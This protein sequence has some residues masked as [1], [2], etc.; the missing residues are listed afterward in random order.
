M[1]DEPTRFFN[2]TKFIT[3]ISAVAALTSAVAYLI[4]G[5]KTTAVTVNLQSEQKQAPMA[6]EA[7]DF[8]VNYAYRSSGQEAFKPLTDGSVLFS[9]DT[10]KIQF[11]PQL[12]S[13]VYIF[14]RDSS[15]ALFQLFPMREFNGVQVNNLNPVQA[16][17]SYILPAKDKAF[18]LDKQTGQ[19]TIFFMAA[20]QPNKVL[21]QQAQLMLQAQ[22][23][24][25]FEQAREI[26][27]QM[28][29]GFQ[30][31][32]LA[33][34]VPDQNGTETIFPWTNDQNSIVPA[35]QLK[36]LC[37]DCISVVRFDHR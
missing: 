35:Q 14:Q 3:L 8:S 30:S 13:Y 15:G 11:T 26:G 36:G 25:Q 24:R 9:G 23:Q 27:G 19:E 33:T 4:Y 21:E 10:Y 5:P 1:S 18:Q 32:G 37:V 22:R 17:I 6:A 28:A 29:S 34:I 2:L 16:G 7:L 31:R 20:R 12:D